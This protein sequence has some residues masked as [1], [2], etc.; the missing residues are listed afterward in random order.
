MTDDEA[1]TAFLIESGHLKRTKRTDWWIAGIRD[2]ESV[3]EHSYRTG[4]VA[5]VLALMEG[6]DA[7]K[8]AALALFHGLRPGSGISL[9]QGRRS[10]RPRRLRT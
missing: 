10:P 8:A 4:I 6:A 1:T 9:R 2:P 7:N 3:A 5:Y